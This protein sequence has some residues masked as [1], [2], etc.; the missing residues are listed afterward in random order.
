MLDDFCTVQHA[1]DAYGVVVNLDSETVDTG[2][3]EALRSRMR[4][5]PGRAAS[6]SAAVEQS[7]DAARRG[8][9]AALEA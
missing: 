2:A 9:R 8:S 6:R 4:A 3:T 7:G 1:K 5:E